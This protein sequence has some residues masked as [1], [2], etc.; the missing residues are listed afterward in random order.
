V[1]TADKV[2]VTIG[3]PCT[4]SGVGTTETYDAR[5]AGSPEFIAFAAFDAGLID[6]EARG[7]GELELRWLGGDHAGQRTSI[8]E[9]ESLTAPPFGP[10]SV[11]E[12]SMTL[13]TTQPIS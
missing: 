2:L 4:L 5:V 10:I 1:L 8:T 3:T 11:S 7:T 13:S 9:I 12:S 6:I